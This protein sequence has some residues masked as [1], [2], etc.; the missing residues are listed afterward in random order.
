MSKGTIPAGTKEV[1]FGGV[2]TLDTKTFRGSV[3]IDNQPQD[4]DVSAF[5]KGMKKADFA[6]VLSIVQEMHRQGAA[7]R[8]G[9]TASDVVV[10]DDLMVQ[11]TE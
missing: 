4:V 11:P 2:I 8:H 9:A 5:A 6:G 3:I 1:E 10:P 7:Q